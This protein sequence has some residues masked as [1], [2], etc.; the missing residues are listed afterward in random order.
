VPEHDGPHFRYSGMLV[1]PHAVQER[2]PFWIGG[3]TPR[4][5]RRARERGDGWMPFGL[6]HDRLAEMLE[7]ADLP[8]GFEVVLGAGRPL[9]PIG[10]PDR[11]RRAVERTR[12]AGATIVNAHVAADS[13]DHYVEQLEALA[14]LEGDR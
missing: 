4:S 8:E 11:T 2:V 14:L 12:A 10:E 13:V 1:Q 7:A 6:R 3:Y 5:L 9:D